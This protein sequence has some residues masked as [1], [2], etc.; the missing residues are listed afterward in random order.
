VR[1][2]SHSIRASQNDSQRHMMFE[3]LIL[4]AVIFVALCSAPTS[5]AQASDVYITPD[6]SGQ[7]VCTNSPQP[8][9]FFNNSGNWGA[10]ANQIGPGTTVHLCGTFNAPAGADGFLTI[11]GSGSSGN[12]IVV[13]WESGAIV[14]SPVFSAVHGAIDLNNQQFVTLDGGSNGVV[15]NTA[16]GTGLANQSSSILIGGAGNGCVVKNLALHS[17][18]V[19]L[20]GDTGGGGSYGIDLDGGSNITIGPGNTIDNA[21]VGILYGF[22]GNSNFEIAGNTIYNSNQAIEIGNLGSGTL[23]GLSVHDNTI[24]DWSNWDNSANT[25]HHNALH[26]FVVGFPGNITGTYE[27]F[28]NTMY[29]D[30][31]NH[32]T[33]MIFLED[34]SGG[35]MGPPSVFNNTFNH[36]SA[37]NASA[38][39]LIAV[40][41]PN[42][43]LYNNTFVDVGGTGNFAWNGADFAA[44]GWAVEN[45]IFSG[46]NTYI[47]VEPGQSITADYNEYFGSR[48]GWDYR[49]S[50]PTSLAQWRS[51]CS[52]DSHA[53]GLDP[54]LNT[55]LTI[56]TGSGAG[57]AATNFTDLNITLLDHDKAGLLRPIVNAWDIGAYMLS[58]SANL[59]NPPSG[60]VASVN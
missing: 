45:N 10:G 34:N 54:K 3:F 55:N 17:V 50:I 40:Q 60:L 38:N 24:H 28:N 26:I 52:C 6:G 56:Q 29:G 44:S 32:A 35:Q 51:M 12:N 42:G 22:S 41:V 5:F 59:P 30:L 43:K 37:A 49:G 46:M 2:E 53:N 1:F 8:P 19:H 21:D 14:Q 33:S 11:R 9:S 7:G 25:F 18:Y 20:S 39:G 13:L 58:G 23:N 16:N 57:G 4:L 36:T 27:I 31:G 15:Q 47:Y 48:N